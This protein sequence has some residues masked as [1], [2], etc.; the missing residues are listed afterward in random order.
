MTRTQTKPKTQSKP[1]T[2]A[3]PQTQSKPQTRPRKKKSK[4]TLIRL[5]LS[6]VFV[7]S[8]ALN[9]QNYMEKENVMK[10]IDYATYSKYNMDFMRDVCK[11]VD[12]NHKHKRF[13]LEK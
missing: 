5:F 8:L 11:R 7:L 2:Q 1:R 6:F 9:I 13:R 10:L 3:K 4:L 12:E